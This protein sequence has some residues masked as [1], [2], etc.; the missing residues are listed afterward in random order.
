MRRTSVPWSDPVDQEISKALAWPLIRRADELREQYR[1]MQLKKMLLKYGIKSFNV[2]DLGLAKG[3]MR[4]ILERTDIPEALEDAM[5]VV[6]AYHH[7]NKLD[8]YNIRLR[9]MCET[10]L[11]ADASS[12]LMQRN[13]GE[14]MDKAGKYPWRLTDIEAFVVAKQL[15]M[16]IG[17]SL[18]A[19]AV[20]ARS[21]LEQDPLASTRA[22]AIL[23]AA[24]QISRYIVDSVNTVALEN[25]KSEALELSQRFSTLYALLTEFQIIESWSSIH[26]ESTKMIILESMADKVFRGVTR[27]LESTTG[28]KDKGKGKGVSKKHTLSY[29]ESNAQTGI[30]TERKLAVLFR[31]VS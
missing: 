3:L 13:Q 27:A 15:L 29:L 4:Y 26:L 7:L 16:W 8:A 12:L 14:G 17:V 6:N 23:K 21:S 22:T 18:D 9:K 25:Y 2:G 20:K 28:R 1:L 11:S 30:S 5:L 19:F 31:Y 24:L 10:G